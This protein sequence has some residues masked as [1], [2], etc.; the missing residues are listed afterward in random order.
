M[1]TENIRIPQLAQISSYSRLI[2]DISDE[3]LVVLRDRPAEQV[4]TPEQPPSTQRG[5]GRDD[6]GPSG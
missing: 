2:Q 1:S 5:A 3:A 6:E 4:A